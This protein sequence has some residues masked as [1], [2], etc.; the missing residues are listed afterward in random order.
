MFGAPCR[1]PRGANI[2]N[3]LW[4]YLIK[5]TCGT[6]KARGVCNGAPG[7]KGSITLGK[8]Y[9]GSL[10]QTGSRI[11]Y[12]TCAILNYLIYCAD[13][14]NA[15]AE[16]PPPKA[17]LYMRPDQQFRDWW[18]KVKQRPPIPANYVLPVQRAIQGHPESPRLWM[19]LINGILVNDLSLTPTSHEPCLYS[20]T[21]NGHPVL[22]LRQVDDFAVGCETEDTAKSL[23]EAIN[24]K[25]TIDIKYEGILQR[26]NGVD[27]EQSSTMIKITAHKYIDKILKG[28]NWLD[29]NDIQLSHV[30]TPMHNDRKYIHELELTEGPPTEKEQLQLEKEMGFSYRRGV[31]ELIY[32]MVTCRPDISYAVIKLSQ[33]SQKPA[34]IH[35]EGIK[36]IFFYL[37]STKTDG[38]TYWR[39]ESNPSLPPSEDATHPPPDQDQTSIKSIE[40]EADVMHGY[41]DSD[42]GGDKQH[43]RSVT[44]YLLKLTGGCIVYK[45]KYQTVIAHSSSEAEYQAACDAGKAILYVRSILQEIGLDQHHA[46]TLHID[47]NGALIMANTQQPTRGARHMDIKTKSLQQWVEQ[48][49]MILRRIDTTINSSDALTKALGRILH[50][51]HMNFIMGKYPPTYVSTNKKKVTFH[52]NVTTQPLSY[53]ENSR[54]DFPEHGGEGQT[55]YQDEYHSPHI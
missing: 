32:A 22:V 12:A 51:Q 15:F 21:F 11:F 23:I 3:F 13:V 14:S 47:N 2:L 33:Y 28:H 54:L 17:P 45:S 35:Y 27:V 25:M 38:I 6:K 43:R 46:T 44:G 37:K 53:S 39:R 30:P 42:W 26:F 50:H 10:E 1:L 8:T 48:D 36:R 7:K 24:A 19:T 5:L 4:T 34:K 18:E 49:L 29:T 55:S 52:E 41:T 31:G 40:N 20:G 16:A 9:A